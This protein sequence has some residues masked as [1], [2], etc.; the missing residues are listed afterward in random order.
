MTRPAW[1]H[2]GVLR[3]LL[4]FALIVVPVYGLDVL[5]GPVYVG[6]AWLIM[7]SMQL[8]AGIFGFKE[9]PLFKAPPEAQKVPTVNF[10]QKPTP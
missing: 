7:L 4:L 6:A 3:T 10:G 1:T 2:D 9:Y 5:P 8:T